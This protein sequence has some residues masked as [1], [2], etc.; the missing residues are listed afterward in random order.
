M[1]SFE[2]VV[3][4][5]GPS[6][7][8]ALLRLNKKGTCIIDIGEKPRHSFP[9][10]TLAQGL[11][12]K[13]PEK[14]LGEN[15]EF[16]ANL[17][18]ADHIHPKLRADALRH[19]M[20]GEFY[21]VFDET[22]TNLVNGHG[23]HALGGMANVWG[24]QLLRYLPEDF[25]NHDKWPLCVKELSPYYDLLEKEI[26]ISGKNDALAFYLGQSDH[27]LPP[28][29]MVSS[30]S[31]LLKRF[32]SLKNHRKDKIVQLGR[33]RLAVLTHSYNGRSPHLF[34][35]TEFFST[36]QTGFYTPQATFQKIVAQG[37]VDYRTKTKFL[38]FKEGNDW[39]HVTLCDLRSNQQYTIRTKNLLIGCG[40]IQTSRLVV[41]CLGNNKEELPFIDHPSL[42]LPIFFP[43]NFGSPLP[44]H[45][46]PIQL[47]GTQARQG[48][49]NMI[50]FYYPGGV[51]W[52]DFLTEI[53]LPMHLARK[54]FPIILS[55]M[56]VAQIWEAAK[57]NSANKLCI[58]KGCNLQIFYKKND[59]LLRIGK[60][61]KDLRYVGGITH[62]RLARISPPSWGFHH[63]GT[64]PM[65][66][67]PARFQTYP[68]GSLWSNRKVRIID[69]SVLPSLP[70]KNCSLTIMANAARIADT[71]I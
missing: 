26:G 60:L 15:W 49:R 42:L 37:L 50:S 29:P 70:A 33:A 36:R 10:E 54:A 8:G 59:Q 51:L 64:L 34:G 7:T 19:V 6:G 23:S 24:G 53:P 44:A 16:M 22:G 62:K 69:G 66:K 45:S 41:D 31:Q 25:E 28:V 67:S 40:T 14:L 12:A 58:H 9:Y 3:I 11:E 17:Q 27:L 43:A 13:V 55:G 30:A 52:S 61:I 57:P 47:V 2:H 4:G 39:V 21:S 71:T 20:S 1:E 46:F 32:E 63:V 68:D 38:T 48:Y 56:L 35:E 18:K 65:Q 5:S